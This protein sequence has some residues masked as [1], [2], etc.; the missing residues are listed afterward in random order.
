MNNSNLWDDYYFHLL[1]DDSTPPSLENI[2]MTNQELVM[3]TGIH[4]TYSTMVL[5]L[6]DSSLTLS[7]YVDGYYYFD[8]QDRFQYLEHHF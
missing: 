3:I 2:N 8:P 4:P 5:F 1:F 7:H 6:K